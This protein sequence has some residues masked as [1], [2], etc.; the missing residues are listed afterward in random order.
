MQFTSPS[1]LF[2]ELSVHYIPNT[3]FRRERRTPLSAFH[4]PSPASPAHFTHYNTPQT[5]PLTMSR[6]SSHHPCYVHCEVKRNLS[7]LSRKA[8]NLL[9]PSRSQKIVSKRKGQRF[10]LESQASLASAILRKLQLESEPR[11][12]LHATCRF[13]D[14]FVVR[15]GAV[16]NCQHQRESWSSFLFDKREYGRGV[17][18]RSGSQATRSRFVALGRMGPIPSVLRPGHGRFGKATLRKTGPIPS[19]LR[20]GHGRVGKATL[21]R[22]GPIPSILRPGHG[23]LGKATWTSK[24]AV[25]LS[26]S[27]PSRPP[28][29]ASSAAY[30]VSKDVRRTDHAPEGDRP[31]LRPDTLMQ[32]WSEWSEGWEQSVGTINADAI[33]KF[34]FSADE[35]VEESCCHRDSE[36]WVSLGFDRDGIAKSRN[37][38]DRDCYEQRH[39]SPD[40]LMQ[41]WRE[42]QE[43]WERRVKSR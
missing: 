2:P 39:R 28:R 17:T 19:I 14:G 7:S 21:R 24:G 42:W 15:N 41:D 4:H 31:P 35:A 12:G 37:L 20:P 36:P 18:D 11:L 29:L 9:Y 38:V 5:Y 25:S 43:G 22:K 30:E 10:S 34:V 13:C 23:R 40:M 33:P 26:T 3:E 1:A 16:R 32:Q 6:K 8:A 27:P